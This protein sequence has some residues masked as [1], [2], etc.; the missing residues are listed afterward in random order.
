[1]TGGCNGV[2]VACADEGAVDDIATGQFA[3]A[4]DHLLFG[5]CAGQLH[6][7]L[8]A[9]GVGHGVVDQG[10]QRVVADRAGH[11]CLLLRRRSDV[12]LDEVGMV[13]QVKQGRTAHGCSVGWRNNGGTA[14]VLRSGDGSKIGPRPAIICTVF[15]P[16]RGA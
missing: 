4:R 12:A 6:G 2:V 9:D 7:V 16:W 8:A 5:L 15:D 3:Q 14:G 1:M 10:V 13:F 11:G